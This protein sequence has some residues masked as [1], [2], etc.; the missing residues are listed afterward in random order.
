[1]CNS[2]AAP[3]NGL[4]RYPNVEVTFTAASGGRNPD[5]GWG[6][7]ASFSSVGAGACAAVG[8][9]AT[10]EI[11]SISGEMSAEADLT[12]LTGTADEA[13]LLEIFGLLKL[14][15][16]SLSAVT[17]CCGAVADVAVSAVTAGD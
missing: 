5:D 13:G 6:A 15:A 2:P 12:A 11:W 7:V 8:D 14:T 9:G 1:M 17:A 10:A 3:V 4:V 16:I